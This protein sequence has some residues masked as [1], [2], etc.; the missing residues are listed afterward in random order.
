MNTLDLAVPYD[1]QIEGSP[2]KLEI[3]KMRIDT[4]ATAR[5]LWRK[6]EP[7]QLDRIKNFVVIKKQVDGQPPYD[8]GELNKLGLSYASN[9]N[10]RD[11]E[12]FI[13]EQLETYMALAWHDV[14]HP[15]IFDVRLGAE[16]GWSEINLI[17]AEEMRALQ[18][19][20]FDYHRVLNLWFKDMITYGSGWIFWPDEGSFCFE[21]QDIWQVY[22]PNRT[23]NDTSLMNLA[24]FN[25]TICA[26]ELVDDYNTAEEKGGDSDVFA[27][28]SKKALGET[29]LNQYGKTLRTREA[30]RNGEVTWMHVQQAIKNND[31]T[32]A[33]RAVDEVRLVMALVREYNGEVTKLIFDPNTTCGEF[34]Y[35]ENN[36]Y[37]CFY[38]AAFN[39]PFLPGESEYHANKGMGQR[40]TSNF[41]VQTRLDNTLFDG[42]MRAATT[43]VRSRTGRGRDVRGPRW[44]HAGI[45]DIGEMEFVQS[46]MNTNITPM[47]DIQER[48]RRKLQQN[49]NYTSY[50]PSAS[51][52]N[53]KT[54][55]EIQANVVRSSGIQKNRAEHFYN[56]M[57]AFARIFLRK[58]IK[59]A[60]TSAK[61]SELAKRFVENCRQRTGI[62]DLF[63]FP[64]GARKDYELNYGLPPGVKVSHARALGSGNMLANQQQASQILQ[65]AAQLSPTGRQ[66]A[67][68]DYIR[69][70]RGA[71]GGWD[72][73]Y[74]PSN[75]RMQQTFPE[76]SII[77]LENIA[78]HQGGTPK[79][80]E[81]NEDGAHLE[82]HLREFINYAQSVA[83][84]PQELQRAA[85]I[86][87]QIAGP[88]IVQHLQR[89]SVD[90]ANKTKFDEYHALASQ[91]DNLTRQIVGNAKTQAEA[92]QRA[93]QQQQQQL[94]D[95]QQIGTSQDPKMVKVFREDA[96]KTVEMGL[97]DRRENLKVVLDASR[98]DKETEAE[99]N[100]EQ[101]RETEVSSGDGKPS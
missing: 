64:K 91:L 36:Q 78:I 66:N 73:R 53:Y 88:H 74:F 81:S 50:D 4:A 33:D 97:K 52:S 98:K 27:G 65:V 89:Y 47:A 68:V 17:C 5:S 57:D 31:I 18:E 45:I 63:K 46:F 85:Q 40:T 13:E 54:L 1:N 7:D 96:R 75:E 24:M 83:D 77:A 15:F 90:P 19:E 69:A 67:V 8:Q 6:L 87:D 79:V 70:V 41:E 82:G 22:L 16:Q 95:A 84:N 44:V 80:A 34:L 2:A 37:E 94:A 23:K 35:M 55:G 99:V 49:N 51:Q 14:P 60:N 38:D 30:F 12:A 100:R 3:P 28:W 93:Q 101:Q 56:Y 48:F 21:H 9:S 61:C 26:Q 72:E 11:M 10:W 71:R 62:P 43:Y 20:W 32:F 59:A 42:A 39:L 92:Q 25:I 58:V 76:D 86:L 29:L